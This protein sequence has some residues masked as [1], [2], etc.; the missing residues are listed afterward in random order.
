MLHWL[1]FGGLEVRPSVNEV[2]PCH[3]S[4][5]SPKVISSHL[6]SSQLSCEQQQAVDEVIE[7]ARLDER[8]DAMPTRHAH[9]ARSQDLKPRALGHALEPNT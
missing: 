7:A 9:D 3:L 4:R 5:P 1:G 2:I 8:A 6:K